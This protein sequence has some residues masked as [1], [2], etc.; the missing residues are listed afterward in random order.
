MIA[1]EYIDGNVADWNS[2]SDDRCLCDVDA[3]IV[4]RLSMKQRAFDEGLRRLER[5][6]EV[7]AE[8]VARRLASKRLSG[9]TGLGIVDSET[10]FRLNDEFEDIFGREPL[11][12]FVC[13]TEEVV[14]RSL[15]A[16]FRDVSRNGAM[17]S[18]VNVGAAFR[19]VPARSFDTAK[20]LSAWHAGKRAKWL[21]SVRTEIA[22]V[23]AGELSAVAA[24]LS[25]FLPHMAE[26]GVVTRFEHRMRKPDLAGIPHARP[27]L[28]QVSGVGQR[29]VNKKQ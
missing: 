10:A 29:D 26:C 20:A 1:G 18:P 6:R 22:F 2:E 14:H 5:R 11:E 13:D 17:T 7:R 27:M 12:S 23:I 3:T 25:G 9:D 16:F 8:F 4:Y 19:I 21:P 15:G 24:S 28:V